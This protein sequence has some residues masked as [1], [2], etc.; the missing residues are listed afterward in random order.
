MSYS[1]FKHRH[2]FAVWAA[3]RAAQRGF[4]NVETLRDALEATTIQSFVSSPHTT[5]PEFERKHKEWCS[6]I[7]RFLEGKKVKNVTYGR[8][9]KL[10]NVYL[11]SM[12]VLND[13]SG[14]AAKLIHP[15]I[16]RILL[17]NIAK[18]DTIGKFE[19]NILNAI[20]WTKLKEAEYF[21][22]VKLLKHINGPRPFWLIEEYWTV[23]DE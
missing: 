6:C 22:L 10:V 2:N 21:D 17:K 13:L 1:E 4:T 7:C 9:A 19:K 20:K 11:K 23:V 12:V 8:A 3:A 15:P 5:E 16:D 18:I 14:E